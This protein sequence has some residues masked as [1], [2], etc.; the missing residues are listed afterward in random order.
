MAFMPFLGGKRICLGKTFAENMSKIVGPYILNS[1]D[2][3]FVDKNHLTGRKP[4]NSVMSKVEPV[5]MVT[6]THRTI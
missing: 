5:I 1:F 3:T 6:V 4:T 2:L